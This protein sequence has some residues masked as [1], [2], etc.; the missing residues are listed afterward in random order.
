M[1]QPRIWIFHGDHAR[2]ASG[3]FATSEAGLLWAAE[4]R[5]TGIL[6]EYS[7]GG[8]Y[9]VA[10]SEGRFT[11]TRPHHGT[12]NHVAGFSPGLQHFHLTDGHPNI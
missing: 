8:A 6:A 9:D 1:S 10:V 2:W 12:P 7:I 4:H 3:V 5:V 11:P